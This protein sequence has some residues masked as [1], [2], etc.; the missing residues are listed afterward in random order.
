MDSFAFDNSATPTPTKTSSKGKGKRIRSLSPDQDEG[1]ES[2]TTQ[3]TPAVIA[4]DALTAL[5]ELRK[6][7][8]SLMG[9]AE[10]LDS[11]IMT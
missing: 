6:D 2:N 4:P 1:L 3:L 8:V 10:R 11:T 5:T 7:Y 9:L